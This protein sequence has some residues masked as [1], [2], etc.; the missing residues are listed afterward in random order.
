MNGLSYQ[1][2]DIGDG[3]PPVSRIVHLWLVQPSECQQLPTFSAK[4]LGLNL[5]RGAFDWGVVPIAAV[6]FDRHHLIWKREVNVV[7][8]QCKERDGVQAGIIQRG[9]DLG[10]VSAQFRDVLFGASA[11]AQIMKAAFRPSNLGR[12]ARH[13]LGALIRWQRQPEVRVAGVRAESALTCS[14]RTKYDAALL[15][16]RVFDGAARFIS[17]RLGAKVSG[18][19]EVNSLD[20]DRCSALGAGRIDASSP[21]LL[22]AELWHGIGVATDRTK[23]DAASFAGDVVNCH[24]KTPLGQVVSEWVGTVRE[25]VR[26]IAS[27]TISSPLN[28]MHNYTMKGT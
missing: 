25:T 9:H 5:I 19:L 11:L 12:S 17:A 2:N 18:L 7:F 6:V 14:Q 21:T 15:A 27:Y 26:Q 1:E 10:L 3:N 8:S 22:G 4:E 28:C 24:N 16:G 20:R 13:Q 23:R